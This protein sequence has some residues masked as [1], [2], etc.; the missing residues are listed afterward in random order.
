MKADG[1]FGSFILYSLYRCIFLHSSICTDFQDVPTYD[2]LLVRIGNILRCR[3]FFINILSLYRG[4][5]MWVQRI[6]DVVT[7]VIRDEYICIKSEII[8]RSKFIF[9][10]VPTQA[11]GSGME[12]VRKKDKNKIP[13]F[14][15]KCL[16][17]L[18]WTDLQIWA[19]AVIAG[20]QMGEMSG[21]GW[22]IGWPTRGMWADSLYFLYVVFGSFC[23]SFAS[24]QHVLWPFSFACWANFDFSSRPCDRLYLR[25]LMRTSKGLLVSPM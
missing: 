3:I 11:H 18:H 22:P 17:N 14:S 5:Y 21:L 25:F 2:F 19:S 7:L 1:A 13:S 24:F 8:K 12:P 9:P 4:Q 6:Y 20:V 23:K 15:M 10:A 16:L